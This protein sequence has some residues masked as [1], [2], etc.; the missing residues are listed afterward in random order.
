[1]LSPTPAPAPTPPPLLAVDTLHTASL[2]WPRPALAQC[3]MA[4]MLR[5][6][7]GLHLSDAQRHNYFAASPCCTI[8]W[9]FHGSGAMVEPGP[10]GELGG[11]AHRPL[12]VPL[13]FSGPSNRPQVSWNPGEAQVLM[14]ALMPDAFTALTGLAPSAFMNRHLPARE[15]LGP[16]WQPLLDAVWHAPDDAER[17]AQIEIHLDPWWQ[18]VR[19]A[20]PAHGLRMDDWL[21]SLTLR[22]A[23]SGLGRSAR[24]LERRIK[25]WTG[26]PL[27]E[28]RGI[29]RNERAYFDAIAADA[30]GALNWSGVASEAGF[31]DQSHLCRQTRRLTGFSPEELRQRIKTDEGFWFYRAWGFTETG[32][33]R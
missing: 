23:N 28:L 6:T 31:A 24:Q 9:L 19:P 8:S 5:D 12:P 29:T 32:L 30:E 22:A 15:V 11:G 33:P 7:R 1:M 4:V 18:A 26:Q 14:L 17:L 20:A 16:A 13:I 2:V 21:R 10:G 3:V 27:R 25:Q